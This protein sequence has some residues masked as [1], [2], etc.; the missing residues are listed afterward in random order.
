MADPRVR[1]IGESVIDIVDHA[2]GE[3]RH[4]GG[5]PLNVA[6]GLAVLDVPVELVT[7]I[8]RDDDGERV[9]V[10]LAAPGVV[11]DPRSI[12][13][14]PTSTAHARIQTDGSADYSFDIRW[15]PPGLDTERTPAWTHV[16]SIATFIDPGADDVEAHLT[17][18]AGRSEVSYDPNIRPTLLPDHEQALARF[19]RIV[20]LSSVVKLSDEDAN[21]L[22][23]DAD[24]E[25]VLRTLLALGPS[26]VVATQGH[27]GA[28]L[29]TARDQVQVPALTVETV[30]T[31]GAGDSFMSALIFAL[32]E[33]GPP[34]DEAHLRRV[35]RFAATAAALTC[36]RAGANPPSRTEVRIRIA[37]LGK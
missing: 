21:W 32:L 4:V 12:D 35:G 9:R 19:E 1:V 23:P 25:S 29:M 6:Y 33:E 18:L 20:A 34:S 31:I 22:Y 24:L 17:N 8:G 13:D 7:R 27:R 30:D 10:H 3:R 15:T 37:S 14:G 2:G 16:G 36:E 5:S 28:T 11:L 26:M